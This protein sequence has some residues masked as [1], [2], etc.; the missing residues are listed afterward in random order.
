MHAPKQSH[1]DA[2]MRVIKYIKG[3]RGL[4]LFLP[5]GGTQKFVA[6]CDSDWGA[7]VE[8]RKSVTGYDV[9]FGDA[10][11]SWKSK[12]QG[13]VSRS[14]AEAEF[15]SMATTAAEI[16]WLVGLFEELGIAVELPV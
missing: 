3:N 9:K 16:K 8:T 13:T 10:L 12:K 11:I 7:C 4:G 1:L 15:R 14:S 2:A 6:Y 5:S